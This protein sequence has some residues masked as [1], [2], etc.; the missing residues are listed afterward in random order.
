M[1]NMV[2]FGA[3]HHSKVVDYNAERFLLRT[4]ILC[5]ALPV[6]FLFEVLLEL[7]TKID[8]RLCCETTL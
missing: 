1:D 4:K 6:Q 2:S 3:M 7:W 8:M 5:A